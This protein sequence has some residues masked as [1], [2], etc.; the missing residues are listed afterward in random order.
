MNFGLQNI[1][2]PKLGCGNV[3]LASFVL[4]RH[5]CIETKGLVKQPQNHATHVGIV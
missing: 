2:V 3:T 4:L 1:D 5:L